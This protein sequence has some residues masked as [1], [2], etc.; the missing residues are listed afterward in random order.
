[1]KKLLIA[2]KNQHKLNEFEVLLGARFK[3][4][5]LFD[6]P[7][8]EDIAETGDSF[9][10]NA[11]IK[12]CTLYKNTKEATIADDSGLNVNALNGAP[13]VYSARYAGEPSNDQ[14]NR[15]LLLKNMENF[16][17]RSAYFEC[18]IVLMDHEDEKSFTGKLHG[19]IGFEEKGSNGFGYDSIF[20]PEGYDLTLAELTEEEKNR[21]SHRALASKLLLEAL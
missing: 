11:S 18:C 2:T 14:A 10:A 17:D 12:A 6:F 3:I 4:L 20:I 1:M 21:I 13:G 9:S 8:I 16:V 5:S 19:S 15:Q 7:E